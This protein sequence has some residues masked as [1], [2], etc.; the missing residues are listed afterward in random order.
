[1]E[2]RLDN[3]V[4]RLGFAPSREAADDVLEPTPGASASREAPEQVARRMSG[5][6]LFHPAGRLERYAERLEAQPRQFVTWGHPESSTA[7]TIGGFFDLSPLMGRANP[8]APP[9]C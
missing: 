1:M 2:R 5:L 6:D 4:H 9:R 8:L 3:C 7:G